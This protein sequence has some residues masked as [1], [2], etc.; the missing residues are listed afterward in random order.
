MTTAIITM[1]SKETE[2]SNDDPLVGIVLL[3]GGVVE[4]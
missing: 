3:V 4:L 2:L 1:N